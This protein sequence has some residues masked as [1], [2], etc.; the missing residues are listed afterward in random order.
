MFPALESIS[1]RM[2]PKAA[3]PALP[4]GSLSCK[5]FLLTYQLKKMR[6]RRMM[7]CVY[8]HTRMIT[9]AR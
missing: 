8:A 7:V 1:M 2:A 4:W 5:V 9:Y 3:Q 6:M